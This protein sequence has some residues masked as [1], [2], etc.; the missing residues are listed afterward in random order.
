MSLYQFN[1]SN[2]TLVKSF[3]DHGL[4]IRDLAFSKDDAH[5]VSVSDDHHINF[6][7]VKTQKRILSFTGHQNEII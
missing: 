7:D 4:P 5:L 3:E 1:D 6:T 2:A